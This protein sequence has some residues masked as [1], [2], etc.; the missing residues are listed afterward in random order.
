MQGTN[1]HLNCKIH[2]LLADFKISSL[3]HS[4]AECEITGYSKNLVLR[5]L[6]SR[7]LTQ[8]HKNAELST[9]VK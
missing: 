3:F 8:N 6:Y 9:H 7:N 2:T 4:R 1:I 5:I